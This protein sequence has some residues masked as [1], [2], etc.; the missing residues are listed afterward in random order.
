MDQVRF[1][2]MTS[3]QPGAVAIVQ[4]WGDQSPTVIRRVI[5]DAGFD[6][7]VGRLRLV[8]FGP[9]DEGL[10]SRLD[11][12]TWQLMPHGGLRVV[13][14][15]ADRLAAC[16]ARSWEATTDDARALFPEA[17]SDFEADL[18]AVLARSK[19]PTAIDVLSRQQRAWAAVTDDHRFEIAVRSAAMD[20]LI[21][22]AKVVVA[23]RPNVG[24]ST[25]FNALSGRSSAIVA[26]LPGTTRDWVGALVELSGKVAVQ[27][28]DTPGIR[29]SDDVV[30]QRAIELSRSVIASADVLVL[31]RDDQSDW[32]T[33][34]RRAGDATVDVVNK[35]DRLA[36]DAEVGEAVAISAA[37][38]QG[39]EQLQQRI[40]ALLGLGDLDQ[41]LPWAFSPTLKRWCE[42]QDVDLVGYG[43]GAV[44][45]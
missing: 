12:T 13:E 44:A 33:I 10:V 45:S 21:T 23:G 4:V 24:K 29:D 38:G 41:A 34:E 37:T 26:D 17:D 3:R 30:E 31:M 22:P 42:G 15:L 27:W 7:P 36:A 19:S 20:R 2:L 6:L 43:V 8:N 32:P 9:I 25:L 28:L 35:C 40:I 18:M 5:D 39:L 1:S 16:G 11:R 14:K